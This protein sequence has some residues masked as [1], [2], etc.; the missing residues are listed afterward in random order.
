M[1]QIQYVGATLRWQI[2]LIC[3]FVALSVHKEIAVRIL[4][5][6]PNT[7]ASMTRRIGAAAQ[8][9]ASLDTEITV[10]NPDEGPESIE[11]YFDEVYSVPGLLTEMQ[12]HPDMDAYVIACFDD[13]GLEAARCLTE[14]PVVGIGEA[15]FHMATLLAHRFGVVTTL[16]RSIPAIE[17][18]LVKYGLATRCAKV[19]AADV[20]VL[21]LEGSDGD[22]IAK[23]SD[24]IANSINIDGADAIVLGCAG[25]TDF[26]R[27]LSDRFG[28]PVLDG[29]ACAVKL[30]EGL[31]G[32]G[33]KTS[34]LRAYARPLPK[35]YSG[36]SFI[37]S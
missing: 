15:A 36:S 21:D 5:I 24:E 17:N 27:H 37:G 20:R 2:G 14:A 6:N 10:T 19:R 22:A 32:L 30:A 31:A 29:I 11:G 1:L 16:S 4:V 35:H 13:C 9:A 34:K 25:M 12:R 28:V 26:A 3:R 7:S 33:L 18:N 8:S 23:I